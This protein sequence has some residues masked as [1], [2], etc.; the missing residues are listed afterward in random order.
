MLT[1]T[2]AHG[3]ITIPI[4]VRRKFGIRKGTR[5]HIELDKVAQHIIL[6]PITREYINQLRGKYRGRGLLKA[7][8]AERIRELHPISNL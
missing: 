3:R 1:K 8:A 2:T 6:T 7:L 4:S 5:I